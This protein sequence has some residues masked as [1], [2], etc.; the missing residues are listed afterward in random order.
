MDDCLEACFQQHGSGFKSSL[1]RSCRQTNRQNKQQVFFF[2]IYRQMRTSF[3]DKS[4]L[5]L[6]R[7]ASANDWDDSGVGLSSGYSVQAMCSCKPILRHNMK[8][9]TFTN[10]SHGIS[11]V[12]MFNLLLL[13]KRRKHNIKVFQPPD[14]R[15]WKP[16]QDCRANTDTPQKDPPTWCCQPE[17]E[18]QR[19]E[20]AFF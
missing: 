20:K 12:V 15:Q 1:S 8:F 4:P 9:R 10:R 17:S 5:T 16:H 11:N 13:W 14:E 2:V 19:E 18:A 7:T 6:W 3:V